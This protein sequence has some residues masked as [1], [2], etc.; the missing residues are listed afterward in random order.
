MLSPSSR[1]LASLSVLALAGVLA[2]GCSSN[3]SAQEVV[4]QSTPVICAKYQECLGATFQLTYPGGVDECTSKT[5]GAAEKKYGSDLDR[6]STCT[7]DELTKCL[8]TFEATAC[9]ANGEL[10]AV[11]CNC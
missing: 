3:P 7:D 8:D 2:A 6:S 9:G 4:D 5:R 11:P 10:P 1:G